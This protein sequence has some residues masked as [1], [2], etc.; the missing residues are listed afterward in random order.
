MRT[1]NLQKLL[2]GVAAGGVVPGCSVASRPE[3]AIIAT[4]SPISEGLALY[5]APV[6]A[7]SSILVSAAIVSAATARLRDVVYSC[8]LLTL[9]LARP[10]RGGIALSREPLLTCYFTLF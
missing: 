3:G 6:R 10:C 2:I 7:R 8:F 1:P 4:S 9:G 5:T